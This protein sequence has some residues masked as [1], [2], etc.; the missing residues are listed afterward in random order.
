MG[1]NVICYISYADS[2]GPLEEPDECVEQNIHILPYSDNWERSE[3][4]PGFLEAPICSKVQCPNSL[5]FNFYVSE[6]I[7]INSKLFAFTLC[8]YVHWCV[9]HDSA[10]ML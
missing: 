1:K 9:T 8:F 5:Q 7:F 4:L 3:I 10:N 6:C 2:G